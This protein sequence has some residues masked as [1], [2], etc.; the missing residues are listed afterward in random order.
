MTITGAADDGNYID[1]PSNSHVLASSDSQIRSRS[2][3]VLTY[4][5]PD[6]ENITPPTNTDSLP[7]EV[8]K[9]SEAH[10]N[11]GYDLASD[12]G[13]SIT[14]T[15]AAPSFSASAHYDLASND[16]FFSNYDLASDPC[17][18]FGQRCVST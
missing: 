4:L 9:P 1:G 18:T 11:A 16:Q 13:Y 7:S 10:A 3:S 17:A 14:S 15:N 8:A 5:V 6:D 12:P 2:T